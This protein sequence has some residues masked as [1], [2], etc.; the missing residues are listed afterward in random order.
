MN[1]P[2]PWIK[3]VRPTGIKPKQIIICGT[4]TFDLPHLLFEK[5][6]IYTFFFD[7]VE[8]HIGGDGERFWDDSLLD[9]RRRGADHFANVWADMHWWTKHIHH[10]DWSLGKKAGPIRNTEMAKAVAPNGLCVAFHDGKSPGTKDMIQKFLRYN[11]EK[12]L[13]V[14]KYKGKK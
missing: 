2:C 4:R 1:S 10:A 9:F 8:V 11:R 14:V 12:N 3:G 5:M 13:R 6:D 7:L